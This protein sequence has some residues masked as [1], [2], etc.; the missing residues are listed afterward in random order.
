[1]KRAAVI[2]IGSNSTRSV[3]A[4][5]ASGKIDRKRVETR[6]FLHMENGMLAEKDIAEAVA[7][8]ASLLQKADAPLLGIYATSAVRDAENAGQ[9]G[10]AIE[11]SFGIPLTV[12]TGEQEAAASFYG[13]AREQKAGVI[14]IGGGSTEIAI[15]QGSQI[16]EAVSL[17][18][19]ASRLFTTHP[20]NSA[21]EAAAA[22]EAARTVCAQLPEALARHEGISLF[23]SVGGTGTACARLMQ[24]LPRKKA[25]VEGYILQRDELYE[26]LLEIADVPREKRPDIP[27]FPASR[28]D[29]MPTGMAILVAAMDKLSI[30]S[31]AVTER[32]N[33][34]GLLRAAAFKKAP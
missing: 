15:G 4:D 17:Q 31:I 9:L 6:L 23:Y 18:L 24:G 13:A 22:M 30:D 28:I 12:L 33:G 1:M 8:I 26:K 21:Q 2:V 3:T 16:Y 34:D 5:F 25:E 27:G 11:S 20:V 19:G 14:D 7:G 32:T 29:I 10:Q